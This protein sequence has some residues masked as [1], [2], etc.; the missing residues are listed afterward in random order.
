MATH[1]SYDV[2]SRLV[3]GRASAV[4]AASAERHLARCGR[5]RSEREWLERIGRF[6]RPQLSGGE[7]AS[8]LNRFALT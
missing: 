8:S 4:E 6:Q 7:D 1:L 3:E 2:L 5:C